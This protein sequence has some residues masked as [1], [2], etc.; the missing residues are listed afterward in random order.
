MEVLVRSYR[1]RRPN[2]A[3]LLVDEY[4]DFV[5]TSPRFTGTSYAPGMKRL[6]L[7]SGGEVRQLDESAF[8][9]VSSGELLTDVR[10]VSTGTR[11]TVLPELAE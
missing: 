2:G 6:A 7:R 8:Q 5:D 3:E 1:T 11:Q 9:L 4:W 10:V